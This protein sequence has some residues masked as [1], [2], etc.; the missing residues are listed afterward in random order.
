MI[1]YTEICFEE[2][3]KMSPVIQ[4]ALMSIIS[5]LWTPRRRISLKVD[6]S[7]MF[8]LPSLQPE[9]RTPYSGRQR[10]DEIKFLKM[11]L[12]SLLLACFLPVA[13]HDSG[14]GN[15]LLLQVRVPCCNRSVSVAEKEQLL[16]ERGRHCNWQSVQIFKYRDR[17]KK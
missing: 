8:T 7:Q 2:A 15:R 3:T 9:I 16:A 17:L 11:N 4:Q 6:T 1:E 14:E 13:A 10:S 12:Y 5:P